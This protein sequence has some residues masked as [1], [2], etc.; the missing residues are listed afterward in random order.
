M[1]TGE[2]PKA[3]SYVRF[4]TPEQA[5]GRSY[6]RQIE[7]AQAYARDHDLDLA[8]TTYKDLGVSA[9]RLKN[10]QTGALRA[11]LKAVENGEIPSG[12]FL[13]VE[14]LD[15]ITRSSIL[16]AQALFS[17]II[18]GGITIV[19]LLD[20]KAYSRESITANPTDLI[21][22]IVIMMRG[23][24]ESTT[25]ARRVADAYERKRKEAAAGTAT[26]PFNTPPAWLTWDA[27]KRAYVV[28]PERATVLR[29]IFKKAGTGWG[30]HRITQWL[31]ERETP[32]W[33]KAER[34]RRSYVRAVLTNSAVVGTFTPHQKLPDANGKRSRKPLDPIEGYFPAVV[35]RELFERV[36]HRLRATGARGRNATTAPVSIFAGVIKCAHCGGAVT[37]VVK[38]GKYAYLVCSKASSLGE[39]KYQAVRYE[40][41]EKAFLRNARVIIRDAPRGPETEELEG[42]IANLDNVVSVIA[43][44]ARDLADE[45]IQEKSA[46]VRARLREKE[47]ELEA[48]R[49]RLR[50]LRAQK[51]TLARPYVS[52]RLGALK[53]ALRRK[54]LSVP[55][56]NTAL[57]EAVSKVV[58][59][60]EEGRLAI[61]WHHAS[62]PT[63][64]VPFAS[65]HSKVFEDDAG[66]RKRA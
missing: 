21:I 17:L 38:E 8:E 61:Y 42:E 65:R 49:E 3:F 4:S 36:A 32:T 35:D 24:E 66:S 29:S 25:K 15:R 47:A 54:P 63:E 2:R 44:E 23:N 13:L 40:D 6:E 9:L 27:A 14:S 33:G 52:R 37:R 16:E 7:L 46:V 11:F 1:T 60:P 34:W 58:L 59:D 28:T 50:A 57:K 26:V 22:S 53:D 12:S 20:R 19:T 55:E 10:A 43:D 64:D 39:C 48:A 62:E 5:K 31:N 51:E 18:N 45:L 30:Q 56:V 41:V